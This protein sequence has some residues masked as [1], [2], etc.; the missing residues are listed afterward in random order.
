M[1]ILGLLHGQFGDQLIAVPSIRKIKELY[2]NSEF[3]LNIN[4]K[5]SDISSLFY[6]Q[7]FVD[8]IYYSDEYENFPGKRDLE[9]INNKKFDIVFNPMSNHKQDLWFLHRHQTQEV[10]HMFGIPEPK[11]MKISLNRWFNTIDLDN[12]I[13]F[14]V[15]G[16]NNSSNKSLKLEKVNDIASLL[17]KSGFKTV[18]L[19][20]WN[21]PDIINTP[22]TLTNWLDT[23]RIMLGCKLLITVDT[24][25][26]WIASA[27]NHPTLAMYNNSY[28]I[29]DN[30]NFISSIV[31]INPNLISLDNSNINMIP[32]DT[33][34]DKLKLLIG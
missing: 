29:R 20:G 11:D 19:G 1:K 10:A 2:P 7:D 5:Y 9:Y 12:T 31:P 22:K 13:A 6:N 8:Y 27:Y 21:E 4:K 23:V 16:G 14:S 33:I 26:C 24:A 15:F 18:H 25:C 28:Y 32:L 34:E 17:Q 30:K 3:T